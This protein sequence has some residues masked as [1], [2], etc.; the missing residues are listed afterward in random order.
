MQREKGS[1][2]FLN[3]SGYLLFCRKIVSVFSYAHW[4]CC[5]NFIFFLKVFGILN[6]FFKDI[7][8]EVSASG[9]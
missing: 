3:P 5:G 2:Y 1:E 4:L 7:Y 6:V 9:L 8:F